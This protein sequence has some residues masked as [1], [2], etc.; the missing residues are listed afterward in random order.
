MRS[1]DARR[2]CDQT[3]RGRTAAEEQ[4]PQANALWIAV[5]TLGGTRPQPV[6]RDT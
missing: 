6:T 1:A 2:G 3:S 4:Q 5:G